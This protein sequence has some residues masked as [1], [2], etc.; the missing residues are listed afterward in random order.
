VF[1]DALP[2]TRDGAVDREA[3]KTTWGTAADETR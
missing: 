3:V 1:T 2:R